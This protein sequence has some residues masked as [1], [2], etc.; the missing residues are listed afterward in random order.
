MASTRIARLAKDKDAWADIAY[1]IPTQTQHAAEFLTQLWLSI[2]TMENSVAVLAPFLLGFGIVSKED[3]IKLLRA[4][5]GD[6]VTQTNEELEQELGLFDVPEESDF[7]VGY[8]LS[9]KLVGGLWFR[10]K[11]TGLVQADWSS[12]GVRPRPG[13]HCN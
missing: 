6:A 12:L 5:F 8:L 7:P 4:L 2:P 13:F 9:H 3:A 11:H 10:M 1:V